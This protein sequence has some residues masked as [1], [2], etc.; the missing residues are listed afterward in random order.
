MN[1]TR[2][3]G[4]RRVSTL[5]NGPATGP[6]GEGYVTNAN[7]GLCFL[8]DQAY[9]LAFSLMMLHTDA[10][11]KHNRYKMTKADYVK[12]TRLP[13]VLPEMLEV[14]GQY[15]QLGVRL[16]AVLVFL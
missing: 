4:V 9:V 11:N 15:F 5:C 12:N 8:A 14:R 10:F 16:I 1:V 3:F 2:V 6:A 13:G 7:D